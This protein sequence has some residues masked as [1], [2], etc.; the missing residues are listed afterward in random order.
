MDEKRGTQKLGDG[1]AP[2]PKSPC[3][4]VDRSSFSPQ[5]SPIHSGGPRDGIESAVFERAIQAADLPKDA[6]LDV[7][8]TEVVSPGLVYCQIGSKESLQKSAKLTQDM[9]EHYSAAS[10][11]SFIAKENVLCAA[12]FAQTGDWCRA[13]IKGTSPDGLV[14]VHYVDYGNT[15]FVP[16]DRLRPLN[17]QFNFEALPFAALRCSLPNIFPFDSSG[18]SD[19]AMAFVKT[20]LP[21]FCR[22]SM[23]VV[24]RKKGQLFADITASETGESVSQ[25][26]VRQGLARAVAKG[27][28]RDQQNPQHPIVGQSAVRESRHQTS[29]NHTSLPQKGTFERRDVSLLE[30]LVFQPAIH[31]ATLPQDKSCFDVMLTEVTKSGV[32]FIQVADHRT[33]QNLKELSEEMNTFY[34]S[35]Q[36]TSFFPQPSQLCVALY[37]E[38][39][40]W[41][42][43]F[44]KEVTPNGLVDVHYVDFGNSEKLPVSSTKPLED[45]FASV[46]F[47]ALP[48]SL[49]NIAQAEPPGCSDQATALINEKVPLFQRASARVLG[50]RHGMLFVDFVISKDPPQ[51]LSQ[52]LVNEGFAQRTVRGESRREHQGGRSSSQ[53]QPQPSSRQSASSKSS[54]R[55]AG[56]L[57]SRVLEPAIQSVSVLDSFDAM[58]TEVSSPSSLYI[59]VLRR[60]TVDMMEQLSADLNTH[61]RAANYPPF[62]AQTN[63]LCAGLF[64]GSGDWC[65]GFIESVSPD[66]SVHVHYLDYGNSEVLSSSQV[67]PLEDHFQRHPPMALKCS[68]AGI[69]PIHSNG[70]SNDAREAV[71]SQAPLN[72]PVKVKVI[73]KESGILFIDATSPDSSSQQSLSQF[74]VSEGLAAANP[75]DERGYSG[76][77]DDQPEQSAPSAPT[78]DNRLYASAISLVDVSNGNTFKVVISEVQQ[79]DKIFFQVLNQENAQGLVALSEMLNT[80]CCTVDKNPYKPVLGELCLAQFSGD[81]CWYRAVVEQEVSESQMMVVF[82]DYGNQD[83]VSVDSIRR[84]TRSFILLPI[85]ARECFL[86]GIQPVPGSSW[87]NDAV[88]F[89]R[90]R[91]TAQTSQTPQ[92]FFAQ[93]DSTQQNGCSLGV[94]LFEVNPNGQPGISISQD[95]IQRNLAQSQDN[96]ACSTLQVMVPNVDQF[97]VVVTEVVHPGEIWGQVLDAEARNSL[98]SLMKQINQYCVEAPLSASALQPGQECCGQFSQDGVWYRARALECPSSGQVAVQYVDFGNSEWLTPDKVRPM[99]DE[100]FKLPAQ[101]LKLSLANIRPAHQVWSQEAV[102]WLKIIANRQLKAKIVHRLPEHLV[103]SLEDWSVA[104]GPVNISEEMINMGHAVKS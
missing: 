88:N 43:A 79:P 44:V 41:C 68:L 53:E 33:A 63:Q 17:E 38:T 102:E 2:V 74:L 21:V 77:L 22:Y 104:N 87:S 39:G 35:S 51:F 7:L 12:H 18:W 32:F 48:C 24:G 42:R 46:P 15:E 58:L 19:D 70:W 75:P 49:A 103:V 11:P 31:S 30:S 54:L 85:Q 10:Y 37:T 3:S 1:G 69:L 36:P 81:Q 6:R 80:H 45:K 89:L 71:L 8:V 27:E 62:Q 90:D 13:F 55:P 98:D 67:R 26:L 20:L 4:D 16:L 25:A 29:D 97:D 86:A 96:A 34:R 72:S 94:Q 99:K 76:K 65:R 47:F 23:Q 56:D 28:R 101:A 95:M 66:G 50:K 73:R 78:S 14:Y 92:T 61:Y 100:F 52:I 64:S 60:D 83:V 9:N 5:S 59:Q 40:D 91:L 57:Q 93:V 82:V 84:I